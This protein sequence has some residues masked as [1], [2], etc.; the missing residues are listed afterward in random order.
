MS[1]DRLIVTD[2]E[3]WER[4]TREAAAQNRAALIELGQTPLALD[5]QIAWAVTARV[6]KATDHLS[7]VHR[8]G[9]PK[10]NAAYT[11]C[12]VP[13]PDPVLWLA[14]TPAL[15]RALL[16]CGFCEAAHDEHERSRAWSDAA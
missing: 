11:T 13:I 8:V 12:G 6:G 1:A 3:S 14:L 16:P 2:P 10:G 15:V 4:I 5:Q 9:L 7:S